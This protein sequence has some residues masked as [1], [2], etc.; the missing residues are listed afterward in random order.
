MLTPADLIQPLGSLSA[1]LF[2]VLPGESTADGGPYADAPAKLDALV[3]AWLA[4]AVAQT[5]SET[6]QAEYVYWKGKESA[7]TRLLSAPASASV[8]G[9]ASYTYTAAQIA[10]FGQQ[11]AAHRAAFLAVV[12]PSAAPQRRRS[13]VVNR[14]VSLASGTG[15]EY[16]VAPRYPNG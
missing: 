1:D 9:E 7:Y 14:S 8:D 4:Q 13:V 2:P 10:A 12:S 16:G 6:A 5:D 3:T 11:A 15:D